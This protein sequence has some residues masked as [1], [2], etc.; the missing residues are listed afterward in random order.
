MQDKAEGSVSFALTGSAAGLYFSPETGEIMGIPTQAGQR[1]TT[2]IYA[3]GTDGARAEVESLQ[4]VVAER[5]QFGMSDRWEPA[6][7]NETNGYLP[8]YALGET[9]ALSAPPLARPF[10]FARIYARARTCQCSGQ[11]D[12]DGA[13]GSD[14]T[15]LLDGNKYCH[16]Q[17]GVCADGKTSERLSDA[18]WSYSA[19]ESGTCV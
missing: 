17:P 16:T 4:L 9:V 10:L 5:P 11:T 2:T 19:C 6:L 7:L 12:S 1:V 18:E 8:I 3:V 14:C 13:G 15:S